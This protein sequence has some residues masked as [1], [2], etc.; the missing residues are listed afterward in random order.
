MPKIDY[1]DHP[2]KYDPQ[3]KI[4][5]FREIR[6]KISKE[7]GA[8]DPIGAIL[9]R[10]CTQYEDVIRM[11][12]SRGQPD[13]YNYSKKLYGHPSEVLNDGKTKLLVIV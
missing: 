7:L 11:L 10:N 3:K 13:I 5:E 8:S 12:I 6:L 4:Q 2:L 1:R 9:I